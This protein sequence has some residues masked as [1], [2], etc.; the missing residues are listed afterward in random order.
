VEI[1]LR[2]G[3]P[4]KLQNECAIVNARVG[5]GP[6]TERWSIGVFAQN[7]TNTEI[8][9]VVVD[10]PLQSGTFGAFLAPPRT[11]E[12]TGRLRF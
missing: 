8:Y 10:Q 4:R 2:F 3:H 7:L 5:V 6:D 12:L 9:Q 11:Y 1:E